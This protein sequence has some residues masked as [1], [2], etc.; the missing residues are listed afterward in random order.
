MSSS[1]IPAELR[2]Q[3]AA[4]ARFRCGYCLSAQHIMGI[5]LHIE[6]IIPQA[7][8]GPTI[9]S[10]LWLACPLCNAYKGTQTHAVDPATGEQAALFNPRLQNWP[11]H[12]SWSDDGTEIIGQT[13]TG[14]ASVTALRLN[15]EYAVPARRIWVAAGWHPP[16]D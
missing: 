2:Q 13:P 16:L 15:N 12:F 14:R 9:A 6:H 1:Y 11:E 10:N 5:R 4:E 8:G 7:L 3:I